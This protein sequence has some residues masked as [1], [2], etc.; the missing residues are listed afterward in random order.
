M[1]IQLYSVSGKEHKFHK[2]DKSGNVTSWRQHA[3]LHTEFVQRNI[4][5]LTFTFV[6]GRYL[7]VR[8]RDE[9]EK[10]TVVMVAG[11]SQ[12]GQ[13]VKE[14]IELSEPRTQRTINHSRKRGCR[15]RVG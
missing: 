7:R 3:T 12:L 2:G 8:A 10:I 14:E 15:L 13:I 11:K 6:L 1:G 5:K 4:S 9:T